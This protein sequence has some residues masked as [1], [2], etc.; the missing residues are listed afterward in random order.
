MKLEVAVAPNSRE[1]RVSR[2]A[3][4][5]AVSVRGSA[6]K[7]KANLELVKGLEKLLGRRVRIVR[8]LHSRRKTIEVEIDED[9]LEQLLGIAG[10]GEAP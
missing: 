2:N 8:G 10:K 7:N 1:F 5:L 4:G 9:E 3:R 6:E